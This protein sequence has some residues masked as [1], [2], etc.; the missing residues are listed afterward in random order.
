MKAAEKIFAEYG[1]F[2]YKVICY[3][4]ADKSIADDIYQ[5]FFITLSANPVPVSLEGPQLKGYLYKTIVYDILNATRRVQTYQKKID[6]FSEFCESE[7]HKSDP[8]SAY[9]VD[10]EEQMD[11]LMRKAWSDIPSAQKQAVSL[12]YFEGYSNA[13]V[14]EKMNID[15]GSVRNYINRGL[16]KIRKNMT[17]GR[18]VKNGEP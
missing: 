1:D 18:E 4:L 10:S 17:N 2:I 11:E 3:K 5:D 8:G 14:A 12:R 7:V 9:I 15:A 13:E 6:K 16:K